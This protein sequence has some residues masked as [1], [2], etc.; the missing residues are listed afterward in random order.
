MKQI[1]FSKDRTCFKNIFILIAK[2]LLIP[3]SRKTISKFID[4][5]IKKYNNSNSQ[6]VFE[7][8]QGMIQKNRFHKRVFEDTISVDFED[9]KFML[10][11]NYD[12]YLSNGY[13]DYMKMP[14]KE[15]Q[16]AHHSYKAYWK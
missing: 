1:Q 8:A 6:W 3:F 13:G 7:S 16:I 5:S 10:F 4:K 9:R 14:P 12:E 15:K 11:K 2:I